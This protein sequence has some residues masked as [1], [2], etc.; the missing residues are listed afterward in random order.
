[1]LDDLSSPHTW[2]DYRR[3]R[4]W[5]LALLVLYTIVGFFVVPWALKKLA[6]NEILATVQREASLGEITFNPWTLRLQVNDFALHDTDQRDLITFDSLVVNLRISSLFQLALNFD[7]ITLNEPIA[8]LSRDGFADSNWGRMLEDMETADAAAAS[9][10][11]SEKQAEDSEL[12]LYIA[13]L[14]INSGTLELE[15]ALTEDTFNTR[16]DAINIAVS[17]LSTAPDVSGAQHIKLVTETGMELDWQGSL[18]LNPLKSAGSIQ[19]SGTPLPTIYRYFEKQ[20][21]FALNH[22]CLEID[23]DYDLE[24]LADGNVALNVNDAGIVLSN[25]LLTSKVT[26]EPILNLPALRIRGGR[27]SLLDQTAHVDQVLFEKPELFFWL[28]PDGTTSADQLI[29]ADDAQGDAEA[30]PD[31]ANG[32]A[33]AT[34][35]D[36]GNEAS[37]DAGATGTDSAPPWAL[38]LGELR[39]ENLSLGF[40]DRSLNS[41]GELKVNPLTLSVRD[42]SSEPS[43]QWPVAL[44]ATLE[45]GGEFRI[46][47]NLAPLP[48]LQAD[49][50]LTVDAF[51]LAALQPWIAEAVQIKIEQGSVNLT[52]SFSSSAQET[53]QLA[54]DLNVSS[55][56]ISDTIKEQ[57]L[58]GWQK[59]D[60][61]SI[62]FKLDDNKL[63]IGS[64]NINEP[65]ARVII[66]EDGTTNFQ[67]LT[68]EPDDSLSEAGASPDP[69]AQS[70]DKETPPLQ[71]KVGQTEVVAGSVD[72]SDRSLPLPFRVMI[73][74]FEGSMSAIDSSSAQPSELDFNGQVGEFG[75]TTLTGS[76][77]VMD[78]VANTDVQL[79][80]RNLSMPD[81]SPYTAEFVGRK[82]ESGKLDLALNYTL[83]DAKLVGANNIVIREFSL[84]ENVDHAEA[85]NLPLDLAVGLLTDPDGVIDLDLQV[86]GD[87]DDPSFSARGI[88]LKAFA[89]LITKLVTAPFKLLGSLVPG[90]SDLD[91]EA[92]EFEP[93]EAELTPPEREKLTQIAAALNAR[94]ALRL[95][96]NGGY[97]PATDTPALQQIAVENQVAEITGDL[98]STSDQAR[99]VLKA[100]EKLARRQLPDLSLRE[101]RAEFN[102]T[103]PATGKSA[104]DEL[105]YSAELQK[106]LAAAQSIPSDDLTALATQRRDAMSGYLGSLEELDP[107]RFTS[108]G[109]AEAETGESGWVRI[110][111]AVEIGDLAVAADTDTAANE[112]KPEI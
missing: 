19:L 22:C 48:E 37:E 109:I 88:V 92:I 64:V 46:A 33:A 72:F 39:V 102:V 61:S 1:M 69:S 31:E 12:R 6:P 111:L 81:L 80:F 25:L 49:G 15:D 35:E 83:E 107:T 96:L 16:I 13:S 94:P 8:L 29:V 58:V 32:S 67:S 85:M 65:F 42:I 78:P 74:D 27:V 36:S 90:G 23:F 38:T 11:G 45:S 30:T 98:D 51:S 14:A 86:S 103:D 108:A 101:L 56:S 53:L 63:E 79:E 89:N 24:S 93:G 3:K 95:E 99:A 50:E 59:L 75:L 84:G 52:T 97:N 77:S 10:D 66:A 41:S 34:A 21:G 104:V 106:R 5:A 105:S 43:S 2:Y 112:V 60:L 100:R 44:N 110:P 18:D 20:L 62:D 76:T 47:G 17:N 40:S 26:E 70:I 55:L 9:A 91:L 7:E 73:S 4:F 28:N 68:I 71:V 54:G 82:I 87:V 57:S